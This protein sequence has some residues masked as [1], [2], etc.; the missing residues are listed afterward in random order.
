MLRPRSSATEGRPVPHAEVPPPLGADTVEA[1][2]RLAGLAPLDAATLARIAVGAANAVAAVR[3]C[4]SGSLFGTE[5]GAF[6]AE[7]ERLA[8]ETD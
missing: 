1:L 2:V 5:P 8:G 6:L 4:T 3:A 7:L